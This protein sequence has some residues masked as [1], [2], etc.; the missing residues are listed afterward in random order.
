MVHVVWAPSALRDLKEIADFVSRHTPAAA[1]RLAERILART[2][3]LS[4]FPRLGSYLPEDDTQTYRE[5]FEGNYRII[6]RADTD[7]V[8]IV[9]VRHAARLLDPNQLPEGA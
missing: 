3:A 6:F 8:Y 9:A 7:R 5:L 2:D 1:A 4:N